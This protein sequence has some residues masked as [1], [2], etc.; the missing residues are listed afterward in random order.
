MGMVASVAAG[1]WPNGQRWRL[2]DH[3]QAGIAVRKDSLVWGD[4]TGSRSNPSVVASPVRTTQ[5]GQL[6]QPP[7]DRSRADIE[8]SPRIPWD[9]PGQWEPPVRDTPTFAPGAA[10]VLVIGI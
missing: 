10:E 4:R 2:P 8:T 9:C 7:A 1:L 3:C 6:E 5:P